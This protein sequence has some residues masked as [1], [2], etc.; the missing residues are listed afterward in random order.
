MNYGW[1]AQ[2]FVVAKK[3]E[4]NTSSQITMFRRK[5]LA[6]TS[7]FLVSLIRHTLFTKTLLHQKPSASSHHSFSTLTEISSKVVVIIF[8][9]KKNPLP[10]GLFLSHPAYRSIQSSKATSYVGALGAL[11]LGAGLVVGTV[12]ADDA[13]HAPQYPW[14]H[15]KPWQSFDHA[16]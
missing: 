11:G 13:L 1:R 12:Y 2:R 6:R 10:S 15:K 3:E 16:R 14:S 9:I 4:S 7:Q 8:E 5:T